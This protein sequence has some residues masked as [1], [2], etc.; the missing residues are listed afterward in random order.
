MSEKAQD[1]SSLRSKAYESAVIN[2]TANLPL[3][4]AFYQNH[5][6]RIYYNDLLPK[7]QQFGD[8]YIYAFNWVRKSLSRART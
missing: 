5:P 2:L 6:W 8:Q 1:D 3:P 7:H 4:S